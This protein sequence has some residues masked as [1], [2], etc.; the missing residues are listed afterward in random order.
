MIKTIADYVD[1]V[2]CAMYV[3]DKSSMIGDIVEPIEVESKS[4]YSKP[5]LYSRLHGD[6]GNKTFVHMNLV[7]SEI[8]QPDIPIAMRYESNVIEGERKGILQIAVGTHDKDK[9]LEKAITE[10]IDVIDPDCKVVLKTLDESADMENIVNRVSSF[11]FFIERPFQDTVLKEV[12]LPKVI[13]LVTQVFDY[14]NELPINERQPY[15]VEYT[16]EISGE[17]ICELFVTFKG[18]HVHI[19]NRTPDIKLDA[20]PRLVRSGW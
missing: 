10:K 2:F 7:C 4:K 1:V 8:D 3:Y 14:L 11:A 5:I 15:F 18:N 13:A 6:E 20:K 17:K 19:E 9:K 16:I 12:G